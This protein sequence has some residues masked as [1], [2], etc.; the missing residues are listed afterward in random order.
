MDYNVI[1][2][3]VSNREGVAQ[4]MQKVLTKHGCLI[5]VR[6]GLHDIPANACSPAGLV[7]MEAEGEAA[8]IAQLV[9]ELNALPEVSAKH[10]VL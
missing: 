4:E 1:A 9:G 7:L 10:L 3:K 8:E 5:K 2:V 6:L